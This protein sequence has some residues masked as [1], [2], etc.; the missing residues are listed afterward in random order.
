MIDR[1][2]IGFV[3]AGFIANFHVKGWVSVRHADI[4][5]ICDLDR[6]R[7][8]AVAE[9][10]TKLRVGNPKVFT[11]IREMVRDLEIDAIWIMVPNFARL[12]VTETIAKEVIQKRAKLMGVACEKPL[13]RTVKEAQK[14]LTLVGKAGL[15]HGYLENQVFA[16]SVLRGK[17]IL[18]RRGIVVGRPYLAR[19]KE[20]HGG[21]HASW[22]WSAME[23]GGGVLNDML[24]HSLE[25]ARFLLTK[26]GEKKD[27]IIP[28]T[29]NAE[30]ASLK[31][32]RPEYVQKLK[33]MT[34]GEIDYSKTP[35]EDFARATITYETQEGNLIMAEA[36]TSWSFVGPGLRLNF[37]LLGPEYYMEINT[38]NPELQVFFSREVKGEVGEDLVEKQTAEQGLMP[39]L[40]NEAATCGYENEDRHMVE[41]FLDNRMPEET[42]EDGL[43]V[44]KLL[45]ACYMSAEEGKKLEFPPE[46]LEE[47]IPK[48]AKGTWKPRNNIK[49]VSK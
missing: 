26:P 39:V 45:M 36:T 30:I 5:G 37:E 8:K 49:V 33:A 21:P 14:M 46:G 38:L 40:P 15:V 22:F 9:Q 17:E 7:A 18:W 34:R 6:K 48:V 44:V 31:W 10:C 12:S 11:D 13:A 23:Q 42:W 1:L 3:G 47:F 4:K 35:A 19:C 43:F 20:E 41:S 27:S 28:R 2:G 29:I 32:T 24:C 16:P 25:A